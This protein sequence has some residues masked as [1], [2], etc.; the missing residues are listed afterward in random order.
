MARYFAYVSVAAA[1]ASSSEANTVVDV[2]VGVG[3]GAAAVQ[4]T[5]AAPTNNATVVANV[6]RSIRRWVRPP[7]SMQ[8]R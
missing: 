8:S 4:A 5:K 2:G 7:N 6:R 1:S 3:F